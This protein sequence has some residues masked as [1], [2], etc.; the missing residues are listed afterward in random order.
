[1]KAR[2]NEDFPFLISHFSLVIEDNFVIDKAFVSN[3]K[4][5]MRNGKWKIWS[6]T[7]VATKN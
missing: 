6:T 3:G 4:G 5:K 1:M 2:S 7:S